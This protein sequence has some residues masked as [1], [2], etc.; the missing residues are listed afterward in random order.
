MLSALI[1]RRSACLRKLGGC[2]AG[3][4][5]F[6]RFLNNPSVSGR[7][8]V[9]HAAKGVGER[10]AGRDVLAIQDTTEINFRSHGGRKR[11]F[12]TVGNG[13]DIGVFLHPLIVLDAEHGGILGL[14]DA[15]IL[16]RT[17]GKAPERKK[18]RIEEKESERWLIGMRAAEAVLQGAR[19]V[20][21][22]ADRESDIYAEFAGRPERL[23]LITRAGQ[24]RALAAGGRLFATVGA[25][26]EQSR[27]S[28]V[29]APKPG[30]SGRLAE[31][32][33]RY[34]EVALKRPAHDDPQLPQSVR[35][36]VVDVAECDPPPGEKPVHWLL[37]T[38]HAVDGLAAAER[39]VEWYRRRWAIEQVFR[40]LKS[41]GFDIEQSQ[42]VEAVSL[43]KLLIA[44]LV[45]AVAVMQLVHARDGTS[46][47]RLADAATEADPGFLAALNARLEG[48]TQKQK[49]PHPPDS[50]AYLAWIVGRLG[51]WSG[52]L[53]KGYKPP[54]PKTM[55]DG[56]RQLQAA[57]HG[58][59][60]AQNV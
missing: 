14:A 11:G 36:S 15:Q 4:V 41:Q 38:S 21:V 26:P 5:R 24:D 7:E 20:T 16:N 60:L 8:M 52:Y 37:I 25:W 30:H 44:A 57:Q 47:Q 17:G 28:L 43:G 58:W 32:A 54:G 3:E 9:A 18:R 56:L 2:R 22:V 23:H 42:I 46:R 40:T 53:G 27:R 39:I 12:G 45:A 1:A 50:L 10:A 19:S 34:G 31:V 55:H 13:S 33:V 35:L 48:K 49:N 29:V 51:G 6:G 59:S